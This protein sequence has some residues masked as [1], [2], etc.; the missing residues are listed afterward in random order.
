MAPEVA[1][2]KKYDYRADI[3]SY[4]VLLCEMIT[5]QIPVMND[6]AARMGHIDEDVL[7][8]V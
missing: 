5:G 7:E 8:D 1:S 4:G 3:W 6:I 2:E